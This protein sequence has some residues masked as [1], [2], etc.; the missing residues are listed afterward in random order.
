MYCSI[1]SSAQPMSCP[2]ED[3][4]TLGGAPGA[5]EMREYLAEAGIIRHVGGYLALAG[6]GLPGQA[7]SACARP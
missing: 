4:E 5:E 6:G 1:I 3:G 2:S 7:K